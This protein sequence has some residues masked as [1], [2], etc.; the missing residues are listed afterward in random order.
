M[1]AYLMHALV[2]LIFGMFRSFSSHFLLN[3]E[4]Q[5]Y[6]VLTAECMKLVDFLLL[7]LVE[8]PFYSIMLPFSA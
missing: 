8:L 4:L 5:L 3:L 2:H 6:E 1:S 7:L